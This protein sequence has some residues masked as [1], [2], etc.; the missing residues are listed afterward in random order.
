MTGNDVGASSPQADEEFTADWQSCSA[1]P[2]CRGV[3]IGDSDRCLR[4]VDNEGRARALQAANAS[5]RWDCLRGVQI[6]N[7][8]LQQIRGVAG[9]DRRGREEFQSLDA[10][11]AVFTDY[12]D[13]S[14][15]AF[16]GSMVSFA[17]ATFAAG[18]SFQGSSF[19]ND[20]L[21]GATTFTR[22]ADFS[23]AE[24][25]GRAFFKSADF[26]DDARFDAATFSGPLVLNGTKVQKDARFAYGKFEA[27]VYLQLVEVGGNLDFSSGRFEDGL[28]IEHCA[29]KGRFDL[30]KGHVAGPSAWA[31]LTAIQMVN[32]SSAV[33]N[34]PLEAEITTRHLAAVATNWR[35]DV[36][37]RLAGANAVLSH[38]TFGEPSTISR[39][40]NAIDFQPHWADKP[41]L[42]TCEPRIVSLIG[43]NVD[44]LTIA[45]VSIAACCL[46]EAHNLDKLRLEGADLLA[47]T[48]A[49][50]LWTSRLTISEEHE[51]R[52]KHHHGRRQRDW[53]GAPTQPHPWENTDFSN[54]HPPT[55]PE[56]IAETYRSLRKSREDAK[57]EPGA[58]DFYYGE[59]EMRRAAL[60]VRLDAKE[61]VATQRQTRRSA[62]VEYG[63]LTLYWLVSGYGLRAWRALAIFGVLVL[64]A[65]FYF[66]WCGI[67]AGLPAAGAAYISRWGQGLLIALESATSLIRA[68]S[69]PVTT[70]GEWAVLVLRYLG[71]LLLALAALAVRARVKR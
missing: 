55:S 3:A 56:R 71:P 8:L 66:A 61:R 62:R 39:R 31:D 42:M 9:T 67:P 35:A 12:A 54:P 2:D 10:T 34:D 14:G 36:R 23:R 13:W 21:F 41:D 70:A 48:P 26:D 25:A 51:W 32:L 64:L 46:T 50:R 20:A 17:D 6:D 45:D 44:K 43:A 38:A 11:G 7:E 52:A 22:G 1:T 15:V 49:N 57:D 5:N 60:K 18:A 4:H 65:S 29:V 24:F 27:S 69:K 30:T 40:R 37:L 47:R 53:F 58:A 28:T 68:P 33:F 59:M 63:L 16:T 19:P